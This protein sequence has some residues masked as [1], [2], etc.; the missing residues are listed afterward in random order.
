MSEGSVSEQLPLLALLVADS[1]CM[2]FLAATGTVLNEAGYDVWLGN[3][4]GSTHARAHAT[5]NTTD[6]K[7]WDFRCTTVES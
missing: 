5:L 3:T 1:S 6:P 2:P 4:R 7:F